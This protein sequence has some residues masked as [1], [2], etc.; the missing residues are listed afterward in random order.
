MDAPR[1]I[2]QWPHKMAQSRMSA[3]FT[4]EGDPLSKQRPRTT[5]RNGRSV[6]YT[7][8][9]TKEAQETIRGYYLAGKRLQFGDETT[10]YGV[11]MFF[12]RKN[13]TR[14]D[15]DNMAKLVLDALNGMA[16]VDDTQID[17]LIIW[18]GHDKE[19]PRAEVLVYLLPHQ[20][21]RYVSCAVCDKSVL[22][23]PSQLARNG[24]RYCS[25]AC[26]LIGKRTATDVPCG[27]CGKT[28]SATPWRIRRQKRFYCSRECK[29][30][31]SIDH[32]RC[33]TCDK[34]FSRPKSLNRSGRKFCSKACHATYWRH[35]RKVA[36]QGTCGDCG[37]PTSKREYQ[38]CKA[39]SLA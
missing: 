21:T 5:S 37:G 10:R 22:T 36:A 13:H 24:K 3:H 6:T 38:R 29:S 30:E 9:S 19:R 39:C 17:E 4:A 1:N 18:R 26:H 20:T 32:L 16:W 14:R 35:R 28:V 25:Q 7:P 27:H 8:V 12:Y 33:E 15:V 23:F 34:G 11:R 2:L 31:A